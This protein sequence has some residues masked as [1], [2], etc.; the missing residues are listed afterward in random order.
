MFTVLYNEV[1]CYL[2]CVVL[3]FTKALLLLAACIVA[4]NY[5]LLVLLPESTGFQHRLKRTEILWWALSRQIYDTTVAI[6]NS[7]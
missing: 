5:V 6:T 4:L 7:L 1:C 2:K 3:L